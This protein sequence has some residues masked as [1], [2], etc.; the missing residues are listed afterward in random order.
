MAHAQ[1]GR[2]DDARPLLDAFSAAEFDLPLDLR[3][4]NGMVNY[5]EAAIECQDRQYAGPLFD[6]LA[7]WAHQWCSGLGDAGPVSY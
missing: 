5:A 3:W 7:P 4:L 6:R 1:G 2:T